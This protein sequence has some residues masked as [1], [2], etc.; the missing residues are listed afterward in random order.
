MKLI[1]FIDFQDKTRLWK[2]HETDVSNS[3]K[4]NMM[5][6]LEILEIYNP[7]NPNIRTQPNKY[8]DNPKGPTLKVYSLPVIKVLSGFD[9]SIIAICT[10]APEKPIS[11]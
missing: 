11:I 1:I 10:Y 2:L 4:N 9:N 8:L 6:N 3:Q 7:S 5:K